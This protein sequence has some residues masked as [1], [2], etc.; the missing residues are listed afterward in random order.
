[1]IL[2]LK[3]EITCQNMNNMIQL[4]HYRKLKTSID[5]ITHLNIK[6]CN[7]WII[8]LILLLKCFKLSRNRSL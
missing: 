4:V 3:I 5:N 8:Y 6:M 7:I 2:I 1:M